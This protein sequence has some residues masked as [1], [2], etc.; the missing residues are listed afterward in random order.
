MELLSQI[1]II[2]GV[3]A[4]FVAGFILWLY[5]KGQQDALDAQ[6]LKNVEDKIETILKH[7]TA[8]TDAAALSRT[9]L[10]DRISTQVV[11]LAGRLDARLGE[12][13]EKINRVASDTADR[14]ASSS[15]QLQETVSNLRT[16]LE[17]VKGGFKTILDSMGVN[18][19]NVSMLLGR[20]AMETARIEE[21][22]RFR[23]RAEEQISQIEKELAGLAARVETE[24]HNRRE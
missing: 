8:E 15:W 13:H 2:L 17:V 23:S 10:R 1:A 19:E 24:R 16:E 14:T 3:V 9:G 4:P 20:S 18:D 22:Q 7:C 12:L 21:L 11:D 6:R 5:K